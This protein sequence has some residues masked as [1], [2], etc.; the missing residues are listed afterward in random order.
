M[1]GIMR[2]Q[3]GAARRKTAPALP[4]LCLVPHV[5]TKAQGGRVRKREAGV[6]PRPSAREAEPSGEDAVA[7]PFA[8]ADEVA[9]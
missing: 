1:R 2:L 5:G 8:M 7:E 4:S 6:A 3:C 9:I